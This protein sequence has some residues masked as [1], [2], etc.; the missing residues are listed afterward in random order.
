MTDPQTPRWASSYQ[1]GQYLSL[2]LKTINK[3]T[4]AGELVAYRIGTNFRYDL[5]EVDA[6]IRSAPVNA[7][8]AANVL[9]KV[10]SELPTGKPLIPL[11]QVHAILD[12]V[13]E[14]LGAGRCT[15]YGIGDH[16]CASH[17]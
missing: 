9:D 5:N 10:R 17:A 3:L 1:L 2:H 8:R 6:G 15:E 4:R 7:V 12:K 14:D 11:V 16:D 13:A